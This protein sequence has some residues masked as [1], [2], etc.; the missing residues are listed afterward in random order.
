MVP[1]YFCQTWLIVFVILVMLLLLTL[2]ILIRLEHINIGDDNFLTN[3]IVSA[4]NN[5]NNNQCPN[6]IPARFHVSAEPELYGKWANNK[7]DAYLL[8]GG[9]NLFPGRAAF[10][11]VLIGG[12]CQNKIFLSN[13]TTA[14]A[15]FTPMVNRTFAD[16]TYR[17]SYCQDRRENLAGLVRQRVEAAGFTFQVSFFIYALRRILLFINEKI[18][19]QRRARCVV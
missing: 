16:V 4:G 6:R 19:H 8:A 15:G 17:S 3:I 11:S 1:C 9:S 12:C 13:R 14:A 10:H 2:S 18:G 7:A 5:D